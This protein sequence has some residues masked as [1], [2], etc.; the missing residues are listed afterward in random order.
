MGE[1]GDG[2]GVGLRCHSGMVRRTRPGIYGFRIR[3]FHS[4]S[5]MTGVGLARMPA[6]AKFTLA[7]RAEAR[8]TPN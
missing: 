8:Y 2:G 6:N 1:A 5:G 7:E 4:R 3:S